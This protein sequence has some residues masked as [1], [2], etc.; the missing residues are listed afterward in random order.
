M[1]HFAV[2]S[3]CVPQKEALHVLWTLLTAAT[4]HLVWAQ[5]NLVKYEAPTSNP[6]RRVAAAHVPRVDDVR[7]P[8]ATA[9]APHCV[10]RLTVIQSPHRLRRQSGY[11]ALWTQYPHCLQLQPSPLTA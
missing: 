2:S 10:T 4:L 11:S 3:R 5:R 1:D 7:A 9:P 6:T 8:V